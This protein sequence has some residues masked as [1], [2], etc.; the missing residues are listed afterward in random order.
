MNTALL[1][2]AFPPAEQILDRVVRSPLGALAEQPWLDPVGLYVLRNWF[3]PLSRLWAAPRRAMPASSRK[4]VTS[5]SDSAAAAHS[6][7]SGKNQLRSA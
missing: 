5:P 3:F 2:Q 4:R 1:G 7:D 6:R